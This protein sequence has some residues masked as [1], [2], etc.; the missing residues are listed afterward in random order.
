MSGYTKAPWVFDPETSAATVWE[1][2]SPSGSGEPGRLVATV[3]GDDAFVEP[4]AHLISAAPE[5]LEAL[6]EMLGYCIWDTEYAERARAAI[7]KAEGK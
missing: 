3:W 6:K 7:A 2:I 4:N 5:L 1:G